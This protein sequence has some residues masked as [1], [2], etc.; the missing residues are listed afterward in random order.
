M[1]FLLVSHVKL[2]NSFLK[3]PL[4]T[5]L[6]SLITDK[7]SS[8]HLITCCLEIL[9]LL[10]EIFSFSFLCKTCARLSSC[11]KKFLVF[12]DKLVSSSPLEKLSADC[13][14]LPPSNLARDQE[15]KLDIGW[16]GITNLS[17]PS[18][19][20]V[21][22][23]PKSVSNLYMQPPVNFNRNSNNVN[24]IQHESSLFSSSLSEIFSRK[25]KCFYL[26]VSSLCTCV[27]VCH[28]THAFHV[29]TA[30]LLLF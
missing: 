18:W 15:E 28:H 14:E 29:C 26:C 21:N 30:S 11:V 3:F 6:K 12:S 19:N 5:N 10:N 25:C 24:V 8:L 23:H 1:E 20:S 27:W 22:H 7:W 16:K 13:T 9:D 17:E 4:L 2:W